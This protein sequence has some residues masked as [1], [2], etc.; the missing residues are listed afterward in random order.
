MEDAGSGDDLLPGA[1]C[2][3]S[4]VYQVIHNAHRL[5]HKVL[6]RARDLFPRCKVCG[7]AVRFRLLKQIGKPAPVRAK[8]VRKKSAGRS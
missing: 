7:D 5:P 2:N 4:G 3:H 8:R 1:L 6:L